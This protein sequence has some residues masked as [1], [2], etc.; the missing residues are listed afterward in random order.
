M[1][2]ARSTLILRTHLDDERLLLPPVV[3]S[4]LLAR[5][6]QAL[7]EIWS[8]I[9]IFLPLAADKLRQNIRQ[10]ALELP[11]RIVTLN[12][13]PQFSFWSELARTRQRWPEKSVLGFLRDLSLPFACGQLA[14]YR[15]D[16]T[17]VTSDKKPGLSD[18]V[19]RVPGR[20]VTGVAS[21]SVRDGQY[22]TGAYQTSQAFWQH[23][24]AGLMSDQDWREFITDFAADHAV[25]T[26]L[27]T[28]D[29]DL[30]IFL[31]SDTSQK[32]REKLYPLAWRYLAQS[33]PM[34]VGSARLAPTCRLSELTTL[35][36]DCQLADLVVTSGRNYLGPRTQVGPFCSLTHVIAENDVVIDPYSN[37]HDCYL[38]AHTHVKT[39]I[40]TQIVSRE[41]KT[42]G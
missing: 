5:Q 10:I 20:F 3:G 31:P 24:P 40:S 18:G 19:A 42:A 4:S 36:A 38:P 37:L 35:G 26:C 15:A 7:S 11:I 33:E 12:I 32:H 25:K 16:L 39:Q 22:L 1:S 27:L 2:K 13:D 14:A 6:L 29:A 21:V 41:T 30:P 9:V 34:V 17:C 8:Q 23:L 28:T